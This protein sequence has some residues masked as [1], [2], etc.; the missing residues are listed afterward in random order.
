M[1]ASTL[2]AQLNSKKQKGY[3]RCH[4]CGGACDRSW[5]HD[6]SPPIPFVKNK[7]GAHCPSEPWICVGCMMWRKPR[8]TIRYHDGTQRDSQCPMNFSWFLTAHDAFA[9]RPNELTKIYPVLLA[10]PRVFTLSLIT[11]TPNRIHCMVVNE[12]AEVTQGSRLTFTLDNMPFEWSPYELEHA[13]RNG[14]EGKEPGVR[15]L[16]GLLGPFE[17]PALPPAEVKPQGGRPQPLADGK[18]LKKVITG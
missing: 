17:L 7:N 3:E 13:L 1:L 2:F 16:I 10:P 18:I 6:D 8:T 5:Q 12:F 14:A 4:W 15:T 11:N 9:L